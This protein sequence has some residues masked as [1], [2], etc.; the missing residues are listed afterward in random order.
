MDLAQIFSSGATYVA[1]AF[2]PP[3]AW[4]LIYLREDLHPE[5]FRLLLLTFIGGIAAAAVSL[6]IERGLLWGLD[7]NQ[8]FL[9]F[10]GAIAFIEEYFKY[11]SVK[12]LVLNKPDFNEPVDAMIYMVTAGLGFAAIE[13]ALFLFVQVYNPVLL[14]G[15]N[16]AAG[17]ELSAARF[18]GANLLHALASAVVGYALARAW[19]R[20]KR[21][22]WI[23]LGIIAATVLH[24]SFNYLIIVKDVLPGAI[25]YLVSLLGLALLIVLTDFH[26]LKQEV[27]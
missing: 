14:F 23:A 1:L 24:A 18:I 5:P 27:A 10:F 15:Q 22:H 17:A 3:V 2:L 26:R 21:H 25:V 16:I 6:I 20:P 12:F 13:N 11:L 7:P 9:I 8:D 19:F 4:L